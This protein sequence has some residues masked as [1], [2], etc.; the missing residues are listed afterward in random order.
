MKILL[1]ISGSISAYKAYDLT[2]ELVKNH[3]Q[4]KIILTHGATK[5]V[6]REVFLYL[7][8][9]NVYLAEDDFNEKNVLHVDLGRWCDSFLIAPLS[10][11]TLA[12]LVSGSANDLLSSTFLAYPKDKPILVFPAMNTEMLSHPFVELNFEELKK[13]K[14]L[15]NIFV[16]ETNR[17]LLACFDEGAG[18]LPEIFEIIDLLETITPHSINK[19]APEHFLITTGATIAP[20]DP[21]RYLTNSSSGIT[22][23]YLAKNFLSLGNKVTVIAGRNATSKL[24]RLIKHPNFKIMR[25]TTVDDMLKAVH[26]NIT[27]ATHFVSAAAVSDIEFNYTDN[28]VKKDSMQNSLTIKPAADILKSVI[29]LKN[30]KLKTIGFA[31][32]TDLSDSVLE[33]KFSSKPVNL[34]VGTKVHNGLNGSVEMGFSSTSADYRFMKN[35]KIIFEGKIS[36]ENLG[37]EIL[38]NLI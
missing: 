13:L 33:K 19:T 32:E 8:A 29:D 15:N 21:V 12:R 11:N 28:K 6:M 14:S 31:A 9:L 27:N 30:T 16:S 26:Q 36:K 38:K 2:R 24:E 4:V 25:T 17:G 22:G 23:Y 34:L 18:K 7:G 37:F 3:H 5:F 10:A 20:L 1:A 35:N